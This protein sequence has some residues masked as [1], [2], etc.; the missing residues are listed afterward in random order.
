[1]DS[2]KKECSKYGVTFVS[3]VGKKKHIQHLNEEKVIDNGVVAKIIQYNNS[4]DIIVQFQ[5]KDK[6]C[7]HTSYSNWKM[8]RIKNPYSKTIY[9]VACKGN[10]ITKINGIKKKS[11]MVWYAMI[12]RCYSRKSID[13]KPT[14]LFCYVCDEWLCFENFEKWFNQNYYTVDEEEM[15]LDKDILKKNNNI[16]SPE[17]CVFVP[18]KINKL[19]TK[20]QLHRGENYIGVIFDKNSNSFHVS[21]NNGYGKSIYLGRFKNEHDAFVVYKKYKEGVIR[22]IADEYKDKIPARLYNAM[23]KYQVD[24]ED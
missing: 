4:N 18:Q 12:Q 21:C 7:L 10:A 11:Y 9:G 3:N 1:M 6:Y 24:K 14:Y 19:F 17:L 16:Y 15:C 2:F 8:G 20:R 5:D 23:Y 13:N 22:K